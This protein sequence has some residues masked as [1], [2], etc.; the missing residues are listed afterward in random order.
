MK[1]CLHCQHLF[2][3]ADWK[4]PS[5]EMAPLQDSGIPVFAPELAA[6]DVNFDPAAFA[7]LAQVEDR[8]FWFRSRSS[9]IAQFVGAFFPDARRFMEVGVGTGV[10]HAA[11]AREHPQLELH[12]S[13]MLISGAR[14]ARDRLGGKT[15]LY[16]FD[17]CNLPF[18]QEF[19]LIGAFDVI[20]HINEDEL[21]LAGM[22]RA[23]RPGGGIL[24]TVPQHPWLWSRQ[25]EVARHKR[26]YTAADLHA[27]V[28]RAGFTI[29]RSTSF[30]TLL[31]PLL[32]AIRVFDRKP[33]QHAGMATGLGLPGPV[34]ALLY[35]CME[36]ERNLLLPWLD[37]PVGGSRI[38]AARA[39]SE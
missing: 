32:A 14:H 16:Q 4:C 22:R 34:N 9:L 24:L 30:V 8:N 13:E 18:E 5:C 2:D 38:V 39:I 33:V 6:T 31:L 15:R 37:L 29:L 7:R 27:K 28:Q 36:A 12:A 11:I 25:D 3:S 17:A 20:E 1:R 19:D 35:G 23:L 10:V 21:V 26:R